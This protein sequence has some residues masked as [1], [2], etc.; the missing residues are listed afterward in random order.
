MGLHIAEIPVGSLARELFDRIAPN[1]RIC[2]REK[3][4]QGESAAFSG[5]RNSKAMN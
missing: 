1:G 5:V 4:G 2:Q 3:A